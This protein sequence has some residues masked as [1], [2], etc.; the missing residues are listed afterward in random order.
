MGRTCGEKGS[1]GASQG[2]RLG[3]SGAAE[4]AGVIPSS[5][6]LPRC[7]RPAALTS[8]A[9][10]TAFQSSPALQT[11]PRPV[12]AISELPWLP[13]HAPA[14][15]HCSLAPAGRQDPLSPSLFPGIHRLAH[16]SSGA[17]SPSHRT[18][19][20]FSATLNPLLPSTMPCWDQLG[21]RQTMPTPMPL[22][23]RWDRLIGPITSVT[24]TACTGRKPSVSNFCRAHLPSQAHWQPRGGGG[25]GG[26]APFRAFSPRMGGGGEDTLTSSSNPIL[27]G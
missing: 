20:V 3:E 11:S 25:H 23:H 26:V 4:L 12:C 16:P 21:P 24:Q 14:P 18:L 1:V 27:L 19:P 13:T 17:L 2:L 7:R 8:P 10:S 22:P 5:L 15:P 6:R 9:T